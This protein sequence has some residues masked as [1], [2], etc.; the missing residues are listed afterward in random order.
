MVRALLEVQHKRLRLMA[1]GLVAT[2]IVVG[3]GFATRPVNAS[4]Q[5]AALAQAETTVL[6]VVSS[7]GSTVVDQ[8]DG[9]TVTTLD[10]GAVVTAF[11]RTS[12]STWIAIRTEDKKVGWM[13][14]SDV[15]I[16]SI[17]TLATL[18]PAEALP[19]ASQAPTATATAVPPTA[20]KAPTPSPT[21]KPTLPPTATATPSQAEAVTPTETSAESDS[22]QSS[23]T[24]PST[25]LLG[26]VGGKGTEVQDEPNGKAIVQLDPASTISLVGRNEASDWLLIVTGDGTQGWVKSE[27]VVAFDLETLPVSD[28]T[29]AAAPQAEVAITDTTPTTDTV[30]ATASETTSTT[31]ESAVEPAAAPV[32]ETT[33]ADVQVTV[34]TE[35]ARLRVRSGPGTNYGISGAV[36]NGSSYQAIGRNANSTWVQVTL[37]DGSYGWLSATY[38]S[39]S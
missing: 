8:P 27:D 11:G 7:T 13:K 28:A 21:P 1:G 30:D 38:L 4:P 23:I 39:F 16:Y 31:T 19:G 33:G 24:L 25:G 2:F 15:V 34:Q 29:G 14:V 36:T 22:S 37:E 32:T 5:S 18:D 17:E 10:P 12:D 3:I 35:G 26:V 6:A 9:T 20:T